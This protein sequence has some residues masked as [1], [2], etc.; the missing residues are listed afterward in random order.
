MTECRG[1][2]LRKH[3]AQGTARVRRGSGLD[4]CRLAAPTGDVAEFVNHGRLLRPD[5]QQQQS[6]QFE[7]VVH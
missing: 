6:K 2:D 5:E 3:R 4:P 7:N 1:D